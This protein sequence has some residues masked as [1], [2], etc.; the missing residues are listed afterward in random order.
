MITFD[1]TEIQRGISTLTKRL[2]GPALETAILMGTQ[3]AV[4]LAN[5][6][7]PRT[8]HL[9]GDLRG[10][11]AGNT[12]INRILEKE[13]AMITGFAAFTMPYAARWHKY[14]ANWSE[15]DVGSNYFGKVFQTDRLIKSVF[16]VAIRTYW[17]EIGKQGKLY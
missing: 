5:T 9:Y 12:V 14:E 8:P 13:G 7:F 4:L 16:A 3:Y 17:L 6:I 2:K 11:G 1:V 15:D 10:E